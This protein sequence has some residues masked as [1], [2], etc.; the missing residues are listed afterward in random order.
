MTRTDVVTE[1]A[2]LTKVGLKA[3]RALAKRWELSPIDAASLLCVSS[4][5][6]TRIT[7]D[8]WK[9]VLRHD[10]LNRLSALV[11]IFHELHSLFADDMADRWPC[12][13]N[14]GP[15]FGG[16]SPIEM[17]IDGGLQNMLE[18][19][20]HVEALRG[21]RAIKVRTAKA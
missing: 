4:S 9:G 13:P 11:G 14:Q 20:H 18:V 8:R 7:G 1:A 21:G 16:R 17:M 6:W 5:T 10:Q 19:R 3:F 2:D 15:L 12:L